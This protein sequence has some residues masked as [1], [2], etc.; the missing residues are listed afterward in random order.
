M[1]MFLVCESAIN[2][3]CVENLKKKKIIIIIIFGS[4]TST[5]NLKVE[6]KQNPNPSLEK[7]S[8]RKYILQGYIQE[9]TWK[10]SMTKTTS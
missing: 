5:H 6:R 8:F 3:P 4:T 7:W 1:S 2:V 9:K 10:H